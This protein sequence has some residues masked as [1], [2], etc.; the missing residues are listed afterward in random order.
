[1]RSP[2]GDVRALQEYKKRILG[3][4]GQAERRYE[5]R[6]QAPMRSLYGACQGS[7]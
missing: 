4:Y 6:N 1:M 7:I 5:K 3:L 2:I